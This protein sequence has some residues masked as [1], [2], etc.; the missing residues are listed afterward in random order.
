MTRHLRQIIIEGLRIEKPGEVA[1]GS[2]AKG[3]NWKIEAGSVWVVTG[4]SKAGQTRLLRVLA[5][6]ERAAGGKILISREEGKSPER[7][8]EGRAGVAYLPPP[9]DE[10]FTGT[11]VE[12]E[13]LFYLGS[14]DN[15]EEK[16]DSITENLGF[17]F[18]TCRRRSVWELSESQRRCLLLS[19]QALALP[20]V[21]VCDQPFELLDSRRCRAVAGF[22]QSEA[23]QG[24]AI[25]AALTEFGQ[26]LD[27]YH[28]V[29]II[30]KRREVV[31]QG[32]TADVPP[33]TAASLGWNPG[34][35][36]AAQ[37]AGRGSDIKSLL[38]LL[39]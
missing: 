10:A 29:L 33:G 39:D 27:L 16:L 22:F 9:G 26:V 28:K 6:V 34:L 1:G 21:W 24:A 15:L 14:E 20:S 38:G 4:G 7:L 18:K 37:L 32:N 12:E 2:Q 36:R 13:L 23:K 17:D 35:S 3:L 5:G 25:I 8:H 19:S 30:N 31:Y 11:T